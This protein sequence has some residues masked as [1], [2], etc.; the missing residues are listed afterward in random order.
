MLFVPFSDS[1]NWW[2][3]CVLGS[4]VGVRQHEQVAGKIPHL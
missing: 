2:P 1:V 4:S 3:C